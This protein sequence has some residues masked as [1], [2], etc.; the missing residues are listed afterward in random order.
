M[1]WHKRANG[2]RIP[3]F[4][5]IAYALL[6]SSVALT[7][8]I[9]PKNLVESSVQPIPIDQAVLAQQIKSR[10]W[11]TSEYTGQTNPFLYTTDLAGLDKLY[12]TK[13]LTY[14]VSL[15]GKSATYDEQLYRR[16]K[17]LAKFKYETY[18]EQRKVATNGT[19]QNLTIEEYYPKKYELK[20]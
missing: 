15:D 3:L 14:N 18:I 7:M 8:V 13:L 5:A 17:P 6:T 1:A 4:F 12:T 19:V 20:K 16:A 2:P 11:I 10:L 9:I